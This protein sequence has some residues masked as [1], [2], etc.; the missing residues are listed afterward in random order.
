ML[1]CKEIDEL[2]GCAVDDK[3]IDYIEANISDNIHHFEEQLRAV[4]NENYSV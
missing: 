3:Y 4:F 2:Y 1:S